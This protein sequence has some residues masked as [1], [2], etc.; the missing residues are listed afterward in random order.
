MARAWLAVA[1]G[2]IAL[3]AAAAPPC[4]APW[5]NEK[6]LESLCFAPVYV[7]GDISVRQYA[8]RGAAFEQ[9]FVQAS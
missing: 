2:F 1:L 7:N 8:P 6:A 9:A 5:G 3:A 4:H